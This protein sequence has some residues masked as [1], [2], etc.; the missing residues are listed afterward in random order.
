MFSTYQLDDVTILLK[1]ISGLITPLDTKAREKKIQSGTHYSEMLPVEYEPS[2]KYM[3]IYK[4]ALTEYAGITADAVARAAERIWAE[5]QERTALVSL[6][7]AG[8]SIGVLLKRYIKRKYGADI[9]HYTISIIRGRGIDKNA[10]NYILERHRPE[11]IQFVDGWIGKGAIQRELD[12]AVQAFPG[13]KPGLAVLSDPANI[14]DITGTREDFLIASSCLNSVVSGLLSRTFLRSDVIGEDDFHGAAFYKELM[15]RDRTYE[16]IN[17]VEEKFNFSLPA[18]DADNSPIKRYAG[19]DEAKDICEKFGIHDINLVKP[20]IGETTRVLLRR[21][22]WKILV[23][24]PD[25]ERHLGHIYQLAR[26][27]G[28]ELVE[29]PLKHYRACGLIQTMSDQ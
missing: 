26:E 17:A 13:V 15:D 2:E 23:Y 10:M 18:D 11:D 24:R 19:L 6:A 1:D 28:V 7:R 5:K 20:G 22:P 27:K 14:A 8:T 9:A 12:N 29:Y 16:F 3:R 4:I 21:V 25:D